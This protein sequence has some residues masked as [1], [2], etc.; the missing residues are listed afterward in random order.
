MLKEK[1]AAKYLEKEYVEDPNWPRELEDRVNRIQ[2]TTM[3][4]KVVLGR[5]QLTLDD[6]SSL[7]PGSLIETNTLIGQPTEV[8]VNGT[9]FG[10]GEIILLGTDL[11][12]RM[13]QLLKPDEM[14]NG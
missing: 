9:L 11:A 3:E 14:V 1:K 8:L 13:T 2:K 4:V 12:V 7:N 6:L 5:A 10:R